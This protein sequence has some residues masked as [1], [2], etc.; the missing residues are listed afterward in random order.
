VQLNIKVCAEAL[1]SFY[2]VADGAGMGARRNAGKK[3]SVALEKDL[4][5]DN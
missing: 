3:L 2:A 1:E 5:R 4:S